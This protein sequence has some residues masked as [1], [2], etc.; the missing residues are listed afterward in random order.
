MTN[1][2]EVALGDVDRFLARYRSDYE[3]FLKTVYREMGEY[4]DARR[5]S[6]PIYRIYTRAD[7]QLGGEKLKSRLGIAKKLARWRDEAKAGE[8]FV[9]AAIHDII[10]ITIVTFFESEVDQVVT[11][12]K[13]TRFRDFSVVSDEDICRPDYNATHVIVKQNGRGLAVGGLLCEIQIKSLLHDSW[14]VRTHG[15][16]KEKSGNPTIDK[17][18]VALAKLVK[19]L[20]EQSDLLRA[21][22]E[23]Q[24]ADDNRRRDAA[25]VRL[26]Y[27]LTQTMADQNG[28]P[29]ASLAR[30]L[31]E[32]RDFFADCTA[33]DI[34]LLQALDAWE[35]ARAATQDHQISCRYMTVLALLRTSRDFDNDALSAIDAWF[36]NAESDE[37]RAR[38]LSLKALTNWALGYIDDAI[39]SARVLV[40]LVE[41]RGMKASTAKWN[42]AYYLAEDCYQR[43]DPTCHN[44]ELVNLIDE[45]CSGDNERQS[46]SFRDTLGAI[47][48]MTA[49]SRPQIFEGQSYCAEARKW[50][51]ASADDH[52]IFQLFYELHESR[53]VHRLQAC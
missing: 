1:S 3:R 24:G 23:A 16:Y 28:N 20:E 6:S 37:D 36:E 53:A 45:K 52:E 32:N 42:L 34:A 46:M 22:L 5:N 25:A 49:V 30:E 27:Q 9:P 33:E 40:Q 7:K 51:E 35:K 41:A 19:S 38:A 14:S 26:L 44:E 15:L 10:G 13:R 4:R 21:Q 12:L 48:I 8:R 2:Y 50:S 17:Q 47:K 43:N 18:F 31:I 11:A 29:N 39:D